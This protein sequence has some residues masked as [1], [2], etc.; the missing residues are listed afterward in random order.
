MT[1]MAHRR[2]SIEQSV[3]TSNKR[4]LA[5]ALDV[6]DLLHGPRFPQIIGDVLKHVIVRCSSA[7]QNQLL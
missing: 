7:L 5:N 3:R 1:N 6:R 4:L 2:I